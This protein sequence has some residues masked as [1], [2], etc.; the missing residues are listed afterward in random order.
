MKA[1]SVTVTNP[2]EPAMLPQLLLLRYIKMMGMRSLSFAVSSGD[3]LP[4]SALSLAPSIVRSS[5]YPL[6]LSAK[7]ASGGK[8]LIIESKHPYDNSMDEYTPVKIKGAKRL[9][10]SFDPMSATENGCDWV[11]FYT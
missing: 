8:P 7:A 2:P 11:R 3:W 9:S 4:R 6:P 5:L 10:V 1:S